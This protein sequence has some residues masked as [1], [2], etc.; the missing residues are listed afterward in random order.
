MEMPTVDML[1]RDIPEP[2][3]REIELAAREVGQSVSDKAIGLLRKG[4]VAERPAREESS[5]SAWAA[6]RSAFVSE[7]AIGDEY[8]EIMEKIEAER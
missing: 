6:I 8:A 3:K 1:I 7:S 5:L 4:I 2:L